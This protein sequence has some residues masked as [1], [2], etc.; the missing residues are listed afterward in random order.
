MVIDDQDLHGGLSSKV[1]REGGAT[2][3]ESTGAGGLR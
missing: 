2:F 3:A 1:A